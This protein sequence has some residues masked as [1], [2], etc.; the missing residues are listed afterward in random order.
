MSTLRPVILERLPVAEA[1]FM[2]AALRQETVGGALLLVGA[3]V[4]VVWANSPWA[5]G[6]ESLRDVTVGPSALHLNLTLET[7]AADGLL[8]VFFFIAGLELKRELVC[9]TLRRPSAAAVPIAAAVAGMLV[10]AL[11]YLAVAGQTS[12]AARGWAIPSATD[13]AF[14]LAVLAVA[15]SRL[16]GEV[17]AFL[18]TLAIVDDLGAIL[19][20]AVAFTADLKLR[21]LA[22]AVVLAV[23]YA[24]L[25]RRRVRSIVVYLPLAL[26]VWALVHDSGVHATVAGVALGLLT[27]VRP[28]PDEHESPAERLEHRLR[29]LSAGFAVPV[30]A[31]LAAGVSVSGDAIVQLV[32]DPAALGVVLGLVVGKFVGVL[33]GAYLVARLTRAAL[34]P[35]LDW[36]DVAPVGAL[37]GIGFTVSLLIAELAFAGDPARLEHVKVGILAGS[38]ASAGLALV[39]LRT[40]ERHYRELGQE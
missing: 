7:W 18:L 25:Q 30:F 22:A 23:L 39:M 3:V 28:D 34:S 26:T 38:L 16:P 8:A 4:G 10:P 40:R 37:S 36:A 27:R 6:Y 17:R 1:R 29:P 14:A 20:I 21:P 2:A 12:G 35:G 11:V 33:G 5:S 15:G 19:I 31:L 32:R 9:G 13:I 24:W